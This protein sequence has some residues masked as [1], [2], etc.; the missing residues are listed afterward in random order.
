V[1]KKDHFITRITMN[2]NNLFKAV[3]EL[4][5]DPIKAK[6]MHVES[7]EGW[8]LEKTNAVEEEYRRFLFLMKMY[9]N[10]DT[11]PLV[12]VDT[13]WHYHI[14]DTMKYADDCNHLFG[15]F[16]HHYPYVGLRGH[17]DE[18]FRIDSG[19]RMRTLYETTFGEVYPG[20]HAQIGGGQAA[21]CGGPDSKQAGAKLGFCG[22]PD[23]KQPGAK[24]AFCG[25]PDSKQPG[26]KLAFCGGPDSK[27]PGANLAFCGGPDSKKVVYRTGM[28]GANLAFCGGPDSKKTDERAGTTSAS[29]A[30]CGGPDSKQ[31]A[32]H[33]DVLGASLAFCGGPDSKKLNSRAPI[34]VGKIAFCGGPD[35]KKA[36]SRDDVAVTPAT[37][38]A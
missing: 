33:V 26:V 13:F 25:G 17:D 31:R 27:Q 15:Y 35:N 21:F 2:A 10:E 36:D 22:G 28:F 38:A 11:A 24:L 1:H 12:D 37:Q 3:M 34:I 8:S 20:A 29:T 7:G 9:P 30:F 4:D 14:L 16:L 18:Q 32:G 23:S 19:E 6:L 5:L